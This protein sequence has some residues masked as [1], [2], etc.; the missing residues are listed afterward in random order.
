MYKQKGKNHLL[1][2]SLFLA[3]VTQTVGNTAFAVDYFQLR[4]NPHLVL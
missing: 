4:M 3:K 1:K 2:E